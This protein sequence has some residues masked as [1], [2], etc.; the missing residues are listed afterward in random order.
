MSVWEML[1]VVGEVKGR[2]KGSGDYSVLE[3]G[4]PHA[5]G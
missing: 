1:C 5:G 3:E 4:D 2:V